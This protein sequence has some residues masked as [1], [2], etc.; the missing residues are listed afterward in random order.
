MTSYCIELTLDVVNLSR[1]L[2]ERHPLRA[3][4]A[5]QLAAALMVNHTLTTAGLTPLVFLSADQRLLD[6]ALTE[7]LT[8]VNP[9]DTERP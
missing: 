7:G 6:V 3:N 9:N 2:L 4:D 1:H 8:S 5:V